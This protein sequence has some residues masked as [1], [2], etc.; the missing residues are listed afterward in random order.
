MIFQNKG[1]TNKRRVI[2]LNP[3]TFDHTFLSGYDYGWKTKKDLGQSEKKIISD[4]WNNGKG[5]QID[6]LSTVLVEHK[7]G[8]RSM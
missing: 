3:W 8:F 2:I 1:K 7:V 4:V 6:K 5:L